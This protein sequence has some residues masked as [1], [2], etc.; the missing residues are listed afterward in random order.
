MGFAELIS[1][2]LLM[3]SAGVYINES[4]VKLTVRAG[5]GGN[6]NCFLPAPKAGIKGATNGN[7]DTPV[8]LR[9]ALLLNCINAILVW[10]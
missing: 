8:V 7:A 1:W 5:A 2:S 4:P 3:Y 6:G 9:K 10:K